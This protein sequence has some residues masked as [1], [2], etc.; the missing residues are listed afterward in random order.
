MDILDVNGVKVEIYETGEQMT[1][2]RYNR[3]N[4]YLMIHNEVGSDFGEFDSRLVKPIQF[5]KKGLKDEGVKALQNFRQMV[6][7]SF[8]EYSPKGMALAL[9]VHKIG[10]KVYNDITSKGLEAVLDKLEEIGFTQGQANETVSDV[11]KK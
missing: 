8:M 5:F 11:K 1:M 2:K 6:Y 9:L 7:N 4:K 3:F 10:D